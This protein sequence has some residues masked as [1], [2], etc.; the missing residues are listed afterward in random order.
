VTFA[1]KLDC[2]ASSRFPA[3][4]SALVPTASLTISAGFRAVPRAPWCGYG[5][6]SRGVHYFG[7]VATLKTG[8][9]ILGVEARV[10]GRALLGLVCAD[11]QWQSS[12]VRAGV[13]VLVTGTLFVGGV[14]TPRSY[15]VEPSSS[16]VCGQQQTGAVLPPGT[17]FDAGAVRG[18]A[19]GLSYN[20]IETGWG[21]CF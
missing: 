3:A 14:S 7:G 21:S 6:F 8:N 13:S 20:M 19:D 15:Y 17:G 11:D 5:G 2:G 9:S 16:G 10:T 4:L 18:E 12:P 1:F